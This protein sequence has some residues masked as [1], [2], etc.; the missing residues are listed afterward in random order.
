VS[1]MTTLR[2]SKFKE[3]VDK[4]ELVCSNCHRIRTQRG[5]GYSRAAKGPAGRPRKP[6]EPEPHTAPSDLSPATLDESTASTAPP[7]EATPLQ[8]CAMM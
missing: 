6:V 5:G 8:T 1:Q 7:R 3:E 2:E 4:C